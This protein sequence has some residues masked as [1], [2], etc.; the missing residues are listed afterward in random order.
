MD[1]N[2]RQGTR[3]RGQ[4]GTPG[5]VLTVPFISITAL[6]HLCVLI[7]LF[8]FCMIISSSKQWWLAED[9]EKT[10]AA[11]DH[12][13]D[14]MPNDSLIR[15]FIIT[16]RAEVKNKAWAEGRK[17]PDWLKCPVRRPLGVVYIYKIGGYSSMG[18][19]FYL[20]AKSGTRGTVL[21][22]PKV[23]KWDSQNRPRC[24]TGSHER[25]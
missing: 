16:N 20:D 17:P 21:T 2:K 23:R 12:A 1:Q 13:L 9:P 18:R 6:I 11:I 15:P 3:D 24:P 22:V 10:G 19:Q 25:I 4:S 8:L 7:L 5:T 14:S